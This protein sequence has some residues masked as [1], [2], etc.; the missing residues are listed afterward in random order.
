MNAIN[1]NYKILDTFFKLIFISTS[2]STDKELGVCRRAL[3]QFLAV[4]C[5][6]LV[7]L[8]KFDQVLYLVQHL[9]ILCNI[10]LYFWRQSYQFCT[11]FRLTLLGYGLT[12]GFPT[13][14]IPAVQGGN[15][16]EPS[17]GEFRLT[18]DE[19]SWLSM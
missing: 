1:S 7:L 8:G 18:K 5:K 2:H 16:G 12:I 11:Y 4:G 13:I 10:K 19:I 17:D 6:N 3:P 14:I 9:L 15:G